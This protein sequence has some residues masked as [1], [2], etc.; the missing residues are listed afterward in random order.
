M[1]T[2]LEARRMKNCHS[3]TENLITHT[4]ES[5][6]S[7]CWK[8]WKWMG[9][10]KLF[11]NVRATSGW[12][13]SQTWETSQVCFSISYILISLHTLHLH[14]SFTHRRK[15]LSR[16]CQASTREKEVE[17][18]FGDITNKKIQDWERMN[19][20]KTQKQAEARI[21]APSQKWWYFIL[22]SVEDLPRREREVFRAASGAG[23]RSF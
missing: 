4:L 20:L 9:E 17:G 21:F 12:H 22:F 8:G 13:K 11:Q 6:R 16:Q 19:I 15:K 3:N 5:H 10:K 7:S 14:C 23:W 18:A 2:R 1:T